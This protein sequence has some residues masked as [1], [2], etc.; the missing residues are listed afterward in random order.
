M[1]QWMIAIKITVVL[2]V[3]TGILY[4]LLVTGISQV[5][6]PG[7]RERQPDHGQRAR[8]RIGADRA[9]LLPAG[10]FSRTAFRRRRQRL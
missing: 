9:E 3:V 2:T 5:I 8:G 10:V 1:K 6:F 7:K 4:P